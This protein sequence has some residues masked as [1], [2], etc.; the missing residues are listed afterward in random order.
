MIYYTPHKIRVIQHD[1]M[2]THYIT[3]ACLE[4]IIEMADI[5]LIQELGDYQDPNN[6]TK[7]IYTTHSAFEMIRL[8]A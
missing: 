1:H 8:T 7:E 5:V 6:Q 4:T 2:K 3:L